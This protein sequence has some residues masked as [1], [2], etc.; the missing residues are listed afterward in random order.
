MLLLVSH[1]PFLALFGRA[2]PWFPLLRKVRPGLDW[3]I[4]YRN[5]DTGATATPSFM[6]AFIADRDLAGR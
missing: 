5:R 4:T 2:Q 3:H 6:L 1:P